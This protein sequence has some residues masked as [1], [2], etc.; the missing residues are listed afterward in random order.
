VVN[1]ITA[2][3]VDSV[4]PLLPKLPARRQPGRSAPMADRSRSSRRSSRNAIYTV[5]FRQRPPPGQKVRH[6]GLACAA[7]L[8]GGGFPGFVLAA[9]GASVPDRPGLPGCSTPATRARPPIRSCAR[10]YYHPMFRTTAA[11][12]GTVLRGRDRARAPFR[13]AHSARLLRLRACRAFPRRAATSPA[14]TSNTRCS[15]IASTRPTSRPA[16]ATAL[17]PPSSPAEKT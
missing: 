12:P 16:S 6:T 11:A 17:L 13:A 3:V 5:S 9:D 2:A 4:V 7:N 14:S 8:R 10:G 1:P 15:S